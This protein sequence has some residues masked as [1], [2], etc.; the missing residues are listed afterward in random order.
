MG[1]V[2]YVWA[3]PNCGSQQITLSSLVQAMLSRGVAAIARWSQKDGSDPKMG[4]L[5]P[6]EFE[7][8]DCFLWVQVC[9]M[10]NK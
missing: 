7:K 10:I 5:I 9:V 1:E 3:D 4:V 6:R 2:Q 8:V